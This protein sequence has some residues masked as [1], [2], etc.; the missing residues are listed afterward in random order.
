MENKK[1]KHKYERVLVEKMGGFWGYE[2]FLG[3]RCKKC[4]IVKTITIPMD[5]TR[6]LEPQEVLD[7]YPEL[8]L[9]KDPARPDERGSPN[10]TNNKPAQYL[11]ASSNGLFREYRQGV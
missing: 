4:G 10:P 1:C 3:K 2:I 7:R 9:T 8:T 5:G 6:I 11:E